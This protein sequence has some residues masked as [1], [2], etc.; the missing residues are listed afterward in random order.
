MSCVFSLFFY[1]GR[2]DNP[3]DCI[4]FYGYQDIFRIATM[5]V[6]DHTGQQKLHDMVAYCQTADKYDFTLPATQVSQTVRQ[7]VFNSSLY[8]HCKDTLCLWFLKLLG[9]SG[10]HLVAYIQY[11]KHVL[12]NGEKNVFAVNVLCLWYLNDPHLYSST[13]GKLRNSIGN[14]SY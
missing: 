3:A 7:N 4:V 13:L 1:I 6:M 8:C 5:V 2:D 9:F 12:K 14:L 10:Y 11:I